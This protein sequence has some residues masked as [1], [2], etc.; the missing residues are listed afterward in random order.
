[1]QSPE[2]HTSVLEDALDALDCGSDSICSLY[3]ED[4]Y[5][6]DLRDEVYIRRSRDHRVAGTWSGTGA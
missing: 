2:N 6:E 3:D 1:V 4:L 5:D